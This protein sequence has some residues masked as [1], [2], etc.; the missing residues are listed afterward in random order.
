MIRSLIW[1]LVVLA[2]CQPLAKAAEHRQTFADMLLQNHGPSAKNF[3][4]QLPKSV[5]NSIVPKIERNGMKVTLS[6]GSQ[7][8]ELVFAEDGRTFKVNGVL[9]TKEVLDEAFLKRDPSIIVNHLVKVGARKPTLMTLIN[10]GLAGFSS[11]AEALSLLPYTMNSGRYPVSSY[12]Q[13]PWGCYYC[14]YYGTWAGAGFLHPFDWYSA[15]AGYQSRMQA[16][17]I[18]QQPRTYQSGGTPIVR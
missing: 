14:Q 6:Q 7:K 8:A 10:Y 16:G 3:I 5:R 17:W 9:V 15:Y 2:F 11:K 4:A 12:F 1:T 13:S 18:F